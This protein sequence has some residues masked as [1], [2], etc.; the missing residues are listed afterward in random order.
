MNKQ[1]QSISL[2]RV[3][4]KRDD[5][6]FHAR[7][8]CQPG[9]EGGCALQTRS[10]LGKFLGPKFTAPGESTPNI[11]YG[12]YLCGLPDS[13]RQKEGVRAPAGCHSSPEQY[14]ALAVNLQRFD[15]TVEVINNPD[16][17]I[18]FKFK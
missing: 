16:G 18:T 13:K 15:D 4:V 17:S 5:R 2:N 6:Y 1:E 8:A 7:F 10:I 3:E 12:G 14:P 9:V 11:S